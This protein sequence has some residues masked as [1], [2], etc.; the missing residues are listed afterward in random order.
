VV[1]T[2]P[3]RVPIAVIIMALVVLVVL[4]TTNYSLRVLEFK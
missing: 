1:V 3:S 4:E 2:A